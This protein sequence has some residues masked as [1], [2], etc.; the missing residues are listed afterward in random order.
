[1]TADVKIAVEQG[2][3]PLAEAIRAGLI[4]WN[5]SITGPT[6][7]MRFSYALIDAEG[8]V[9]G[10]IS[11]A[12]YRDSLFVDTLWLADRL[13]GHGLGSRLMHIAE[14]RGRLEGCTFAF[15]DTMNFQARPFYEKR[16]YNVFHTFTFEGGAFTQYFLR[17]EL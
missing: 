4:A 10:G 6:K 5:D 13:R 9:S 17:K 11:C 1:M 7:R 12:I 2:S 8:G 14:E 16:G 15:L 3:G